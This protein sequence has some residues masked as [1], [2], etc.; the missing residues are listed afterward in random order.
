MPW[1]A[2]TM[3]PVERV[4]SKEFVTPESAKLVVVALVRSVLPV[5]VVEA[6]VPEVVTLRV[7]AETPPL[8]VLSELKIFAVV[9]EKAE[10]NT[11]VDELYAN[12]YTALSDEE[13]ILLLKPV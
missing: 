1:V 6:S 2:A 7:F 10:V 12:G 3:A 9:V 13:E 5:R 4:L 8:K 11:P